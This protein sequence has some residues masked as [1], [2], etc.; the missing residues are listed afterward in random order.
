[1]SGQ[2]DFGVG[3]QQLYIVIATTQEYMGENRLHRS[4]IGNAGHGREEGKDLFL[5]DTKLHRLHSQ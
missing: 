4:P 2:L 3:R 1:M 5:L